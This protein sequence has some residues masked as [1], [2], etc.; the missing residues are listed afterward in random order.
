VGQ[1]LRT[2]LSAALPPD[3]QPFLDQIVNGVFDAFSHAVAAAFWAG[4]VAA[5]AALVVAIFLPEVP[6]RG[7][8]RRGAPGLAGKPGSTPGGQ[9]GG[10]PE[11]EPEPE[12]AP[13]GL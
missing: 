1:D 11:S 3:A 8:V 7:M 10:Q 13:P 6:L 4:M 12:M 2:A 9:P 5:I